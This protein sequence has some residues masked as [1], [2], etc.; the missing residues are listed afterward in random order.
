MVSGDMDLNV[1]LDLKRI[2]AN[3]Q[4]VELAIRELPQWR[5]ASHA[6]KMAAL[7]RLVRSLGYQI[8]E[9][10]GVVE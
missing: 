10:V 1:K 5:W 2:E 3:I 4:A 6:E 7:N 8:T 9:P